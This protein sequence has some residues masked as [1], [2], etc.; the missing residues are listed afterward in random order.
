MSDLKLDGLS[1]EERLAA[2]WAA[3]AD[4]GSDGG[5]GQQG[6]DLVAAH[7]LFGVRP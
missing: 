3:L 7:Q 4:E 5:G 2:E 6:L 1:D